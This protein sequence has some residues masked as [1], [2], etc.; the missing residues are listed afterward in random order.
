[1]TAHLKS[2]AIVLIGVYASI[3]LFGWPLL[4][5]TLLGIADALLNLRGRNARKPNP[6]S[7]PIA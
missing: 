2:R 3:L 6:P 4:A 7:G 1:L 5:I